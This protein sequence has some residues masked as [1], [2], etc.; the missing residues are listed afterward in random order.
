MKKIIMEIEEDIKNN[1]FNKDNIIMMIKM[2]LEIEIEIE[3][4]TLN[5]KIK[6][7][8]LIHLKL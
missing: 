3:I 7:I 1:S 2:N 6:E 5:S 8:I 4:E